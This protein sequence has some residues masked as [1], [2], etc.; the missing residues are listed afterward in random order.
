VTLNKRK[1]FV[2]WLLGL[3]SGFSLMIS[4]GTLNF[5]L[6]KE[7]IDI[8]TIG[9]FALVSMP[10]A[11][12][13]LWAPIFD[14]KKLPFLTPIF[15]NRLS[16]VLLVQFFLSIVV[17]AISSINPSEDIILFA[18]MALM[19]SFFAS[20]QDT[21]LGAIRTEIVN[22]NQ[23]GQVSGMYIFGYRIGMLISGSGA[24]YISAFISWNLVYELISAIILLFPI[25]LILISN[26]L[27]SENIPDAVIKKQNRL[28]LKSIGFVRAILK[29]V[30]TMP[31]I[32][33]TLLF[34]V[35][36]RIPD[37]FISTMIN[38]FLLHIGYD[39]FEIASTGKFFGV[40]AAI[41]GG[42]FASLIMKNKS[43]F[44]SLLIF[45]ALHALAHLL[46]IVQDEYGKNLPLL[47][48]V[49]G[50]EGTTGGMSMT[51]Y[52]A[53]IASLC[54]GKFRATQYSFFSSMMG[55]SRSILPAMSGYIV[56]HAGWKSFYFFTTMATIPSLILLVHLHKYYNLRRVD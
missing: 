31:F 3:M 23:Q 29:P 36:Y 24:I 11:I 30:G 5:W 34:L 55:L 17:Y 41:I 16:W 22:K 32:A 2:I 42:L 14:T 47:F 37:N 48:L 53:F 1:Y 51:A 4:S 38:P 35:L 56:M 49:I 6:S 15:G 40:F 19:I 28:L 52:I 7:N 39:E 54:Q 45:G 25:I 9:I 33:I 8:R 13:F 20:A 18:I 46:F 10:Y 12:N 27:R 50:F 21:L 43:I 44:E 26:H